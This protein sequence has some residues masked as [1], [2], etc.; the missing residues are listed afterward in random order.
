[1]NDRKGITDHQWVSKIHALMVQLILKYLDIWEKV[2]AFSLQP[3]AE[4]QFIW[5]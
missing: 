1:M 3:A 5:S 4:V 2:E